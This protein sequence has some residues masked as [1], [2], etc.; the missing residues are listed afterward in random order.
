MP[1]RPLAYPWEWLESTTSVG[2]PLC[3]LP[4]PPLRP[5]RRRDLTCRGCGTRYNS[6]T[7]SVRQLGQPPVVLRSLERVLH[8]LQA[9]ADRRATEPA[10]WRDAE[11][12]LRL[13]LERTTEPLPICR[14]LLA[15]DPTR[16][17]STRDR[18]AEAADEVRTAIDRH[19]S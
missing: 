6:F 12:S 10:R 19:A 8:E 13:L 3:G 18:L 5:S 14:S 17:D 2:C 9:A 7:G 1:Y 11:A 4:S 16:V 15:A